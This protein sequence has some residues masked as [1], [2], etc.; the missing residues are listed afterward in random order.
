MYW[1]VEGSWTIKSTY[2]VWMGMAWYGMLY[3]RSDMTLHIYSGMIWFDGNAERVTIYVRIYILI[4][5]RYACARYKHFF[6]FGRMSLSFMMWV[7][8][9]S[10]PLHWWR[11][12]GIRLEHCHAILFANPCEHNPRIPFPGTNNQSLMSFM[13]TLAQGWMG[14]AHLHFSCKTYWLGQV[15]W[16]A[17]SLNLIR[18]HCKSVLYVQA[19]H[20]RFW[21]IL[22]GCPKTPLLSRGI[23][24]PSKSF[25]CSCCLRIS[26]LKKRIP[27][28]LLSIRWNGG[29]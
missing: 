4:Y 7:L 5:S 27:L 8:C 19:A 29:S 22:G 25:L 24:P 14:M 15:A 20:G 18:T 1:C 11:W 6:F 13:Y 23:Y 2:R 26:M 28:F 3:L 12:F 10:A 21:G 9:C 16:Y 17:G